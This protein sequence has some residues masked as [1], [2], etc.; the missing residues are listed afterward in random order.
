MQ[1]IW[2]LWKAQPSL[3]YANVK[4]QAWYHETARRGQMYETFGYFV[5]LQLSIF[6][7]HNRSVSYN[8][9]KVIGFCDWLCPFEVSISAVLDSLPY[10]LAAI[11]GQN[12]LLLLLSNSYW[13]INKSA[14]QRLSVP[15]LGYHSKYWIR[16]DA[17]AARNRIK[18]AWYY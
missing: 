9:S 6:W 17:Q 18:V 10:R 3:A 4:Y 11:I 2:Y 8:F 16:F 15:G 5:H 1:L 12:R 14:T 7:L 13:T